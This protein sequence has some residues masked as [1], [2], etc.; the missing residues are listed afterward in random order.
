MVHFFS[1][2]RTDMTSLLV[3]AAP[4]LT[5]IRKQKNAPVKHRRQEPHPQPVD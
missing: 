3:I 5:F 1:L 2:V 4:L